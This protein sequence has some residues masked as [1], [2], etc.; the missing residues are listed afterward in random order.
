MFAGLNKGKGNND[1]DMDLDD[2]PARP[3]ADGDKQQQQQQAQRPDAATVDDANTK[4]YLQ[5]RLVTR[6]E[7]ELKSHTSYLVFALLPRE[8]TDEDEAAAAARWPIGGE[9]P[10][11]VI[12]GMDRAS[13]KQERRELLQQGSR[14]K[15]N[16]NAKERHQQRINLTT[17]RAKVQAQ[18]VE[19]DKVLG[20]AQPEGPKDG[21]A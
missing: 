20:E 9:P 3:G 10:Q 11:K 16:R 7:A 14:N 2:G 12:G 17:E 5:G 15:K 19:A 8:W 21:G 13:R 18:E 1:A 6:P 4:P